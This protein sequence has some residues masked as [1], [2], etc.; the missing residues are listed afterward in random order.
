MKKE[1]VVVPSSN[2]VKLSFNDGSEVYRS[3][4]PATGKF[5]VCMTVTPSGYA[6]TEKEALSAFAKDLK[7]VSSKFLAYA[8]ELEKSEV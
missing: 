6:D 2:I 7:T 5:F 8:E 1:T 3:F 4:D